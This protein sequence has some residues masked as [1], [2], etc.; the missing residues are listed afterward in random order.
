MTAPLDEIDRQIINNLQGGFPISERPFLDVANSLGIA[1]QD[2][3][4]RITRLVS[5][6]VLSRFGPMHD[7]EKLGG[8][9]TLCAVAAPKERFDK[10]TELVNRHEEVAHNYARNHT[11]NMW[12]VIAV[13]SPGEIERVIAEIEKETGLTVYNFPKQ[14]EFFIGLKVDA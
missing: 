2:L 7:A 13:D 5:D 4:D 10:V 1:E 8:A 9:V 11:L 6:G 14:R 12:F 3:I